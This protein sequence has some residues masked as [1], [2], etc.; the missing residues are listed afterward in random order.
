MNR[1]VCFVAVALV[2]A[3][4]GAPLAPAGERGG[5]KTKGTV[6][7][8]TE[9]ALRLVVDEKIVT[10]RVPRRNKIIVREVSQ[11]N[12]GE[13]VT[14]TWVAEADQKF[15]RDIDGRGT[16]VGKVSAKGETWIEIT[17][18]DGKPQRFRPRWIGGN[19]SEGGG[20]DK[21]MLAAIRRQKVGAT[22]ALTWEMPEGK[23]VVAITPVE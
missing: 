22:V 5:N 12:R 8:I 11:L 20:H 1:T 14:V 10:F 21:E 19:P 9:G 6:V 16:L 3:G 2:L 18:G 13:T 15:I 17:P 4:V 23:R 7:A